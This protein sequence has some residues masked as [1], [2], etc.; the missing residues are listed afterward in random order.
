[1]AAPMMFM[2]GSRT[3][4]NSVAKTALA[5]DAAAAQTS[6]RMAGGGRLSDERHEFRRLNIHV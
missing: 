6:H 1:M 3:F 4:I 2:A 5:L